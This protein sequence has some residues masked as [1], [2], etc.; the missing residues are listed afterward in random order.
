RQ[1]ARSVWPDGVGNDRVVDTYVRRLRLRI[2]AV[3]LS[4]HTVRQRGYFLAIE[5]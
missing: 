3:G 1:L 5:G 4:I 2:P